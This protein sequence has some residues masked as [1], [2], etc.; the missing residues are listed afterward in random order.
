MA[1]RE[2]DEQIFAA[3]R[4]LELE[5]PDAPEIDLDEYIYMLIHARWDL[6]LD[7]EPGCE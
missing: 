1:E 6:H 4:M 5:D 2:K 3:M 7:Y